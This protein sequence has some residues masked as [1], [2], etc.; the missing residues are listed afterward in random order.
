MTVTDA[1]DMNA[2]VQGETL[3]PNAVRAAAAVAELLFITSDPKDQRLVQACLMEAAQNGKLGSK[4]NQE[5]VERI[6]ALKEWLEGQAQRGDMRVIGCRKH[7][8]D[9]HEIVQRSVTLVRDHTGLL[10]LH[11]QPEQRVAVVFLTPMDLAPGRYFF[12]YH[13]NAQ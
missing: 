1:M 3:C 2:I 8:K 12:L 6:L 4:E 5:S 13:P 7:M 10:P 9:A 11:L